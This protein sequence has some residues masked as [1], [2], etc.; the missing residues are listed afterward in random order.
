MPQPLNPALYQVNT[1]VQIAERSRELGRPATLEDLPDSWLDQI[2]ALG[3]D[4]LYM[5]GIWQTGDEGRRLSRT[6]PIWKQEYRELLP[7]CTDDD[8]SGS[9]FAVQ[10]YTPHEAFGGLEG[11]ARF[12]ER[13]KLRNL[14]LMLDFVPNHTALDHPWAF[15]HPEYYVAG[16]ENQRLHE[17]DNY[18]RVETKHGPRV[19]AHGRDPYFPGWPDTLQLNYRHADLRHAVSETMR[20]IAH[21]CDG[22]RCDMAMLL[23]PEVIQRTWG[24]ASLPSDGSPP[25]DSPFWP[26]AIG[27]IRL[28]YPSFVFTAEVY[29][30]LE[31]DLQQQG[32]D[33]TYDKRLYDRLREGRAPAVRAH[34]QAHPEFQKKS[35]RFLENHDEARAAAAFSWPV[36]QAAAVIAG[37]VP[38]MHFFH[39]GQLDG[40]RIRCSNHLRRRATEEGQPF[41]QAF[42]DRLLGRL[43]RPEVRFGEWRLCQCRPAWDH[44][45]THEQFICF[46]WETEQKRRLL[47]AVNYGPSQGQCFVQLPF[48]NLAGKQIEFNDLLRPTVYLRN[49]DEL[50]SRG[51][52][53]DLAPWAFHVFEVTN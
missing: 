15:E 28:D 52:Y 32:F 50:A 34:L 36:H 13:L 43:Y 33:Y 25:V 49:G 10:S 3:F 2:A 29:W 24:D 38:G 40:R 39:D 7:D 14:C 17:A 16:T 1:R 46:V 45:Q 19:L 22:I 41:I 20:Q 53:L 27:R 23:M 47:I 42:Y 18:C 4:W 11:L 31:W 6:N 12:R 30:D 21:L 37:Y 35:V 51:L 5:L 9:P 48:D 44:N 8:V 26:E